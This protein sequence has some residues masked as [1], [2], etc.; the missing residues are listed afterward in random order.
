MNH[1]PRVHPVSGLWVFLLVFAL[2][3]AGVAPVL[4]APAVPLP[5]L[6]PAATTVTLDGDPTVV[7]ATTNSTTLRI[8]S[9]TGNITISSN[10]NKLMLVG[11]S[12][13]AN[14]VDAP[15]IG[16]KFTPDSGPEVNLKQ[17]ISR[18]NTWLLRWASIWYTTELTDGQVGY[19][20]VTFKGSVGASGIVA[21]LAMFYNVDQITPIGPTNGADNVSNALSVTLSGLVGDELV[22][23]DAFIGGGST[24][25]P[26]IGGNGK[27]SSKADIYAKDENGRYKLS[28][29][30]RQKAIAENPDLF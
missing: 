29:E 10:P 9:G 17:A 23:D 16:V 8:P 22:F 1:Q 24:L 20:T 14:T 12:W 11:V 30:E 6:A 27:I 28:T 4:A 13:N 3:M 15:I 26:P 21:G 7:S 5:D 25:T 19:V 2:V 18:S